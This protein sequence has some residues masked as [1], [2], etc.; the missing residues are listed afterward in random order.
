ME[1]AL[2]T[3]SKAVEPLAPRPS[4][5]NCLLQQIKEHIISLKAELEDIAQAALSLKD[6]SLL[7]QHST[8]QKALYDLDLNVK[9]VLY[10]YKSSPSIPE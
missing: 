3:V 5:N 1:I 4:L 7:E 6:K 9:R 2:R 8:L 10:P